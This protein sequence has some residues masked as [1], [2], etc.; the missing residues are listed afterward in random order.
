MYLRR[1]G[2]IVGLVGCGFVLWGCSSGSPRFVAQHEPWRADEERAC[3]VSGYVRE[4]PWL[5]ARASLGAPTSSCGAIR[6]FQ[7]S[8]AA[9]GRVA[10]KPAALL[11]CNM[12]PAVETWVQRVAMPA[13]QRYYGAPLV[14]MK[15]AASYGCRP[16]NNRSG[17]KLSEHGHANAIDIS[18]FTMAN[19]HSVTVRNGWRGDSRDRAF[20]RAV[21]G[22]ACGPFKTVLGPESDRHHQD[23]FHF[24]LA[25]HGRGGHD[26]YC[27]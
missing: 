15:V 6:P 24:D 7:M 14:E 22:G 8:A 3:L 18:S 10:L 12:I 4:Q 13:A 16:R 23:H 19:G 9:G 25:R 17:A 27:R 21:H 5:V 11:R 2:S 20:L 1:V 26:T